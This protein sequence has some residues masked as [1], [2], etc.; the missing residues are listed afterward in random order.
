M[1]KEILIAILLLMFLMKAFAHRSASNLKGKSFELLNDG[2]VF[3]HSPYCF[4]CKIMKPRVEELLGSVE[5]LMLDVSKQEAQE[6]V[7][8]VGIRALPTTL[9]VKSGIIQDA[10]VGVFDIKNLIRGVKDGNIS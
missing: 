2:V 4:A 6:V 7:K 1:L 5:I 3:I 9:F 8:K 10:K